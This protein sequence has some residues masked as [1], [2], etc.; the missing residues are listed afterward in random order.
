MYMNLKPNQLKRISF[1]TRT[2]KFIGVH[3]PPPKILGP[4]KLNFL[5]RSPSQLFWSEIFRSPL[6][7]GGAA[8]MR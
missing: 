8:T 4:P 5:L 3:T 6:K 2:M 7:L 1:N